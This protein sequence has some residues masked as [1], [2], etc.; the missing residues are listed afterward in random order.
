MSPETH[1]LEGI[2]RTLGLPSPKDSFHECLRPVIAADGLA[3]LV[4]LDPVVIKV[5]AEHRKRERYAF[6]YVKSTP[7]EERPV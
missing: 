7:L 3:A 6:D 1:R 2:V 4:V 5:C